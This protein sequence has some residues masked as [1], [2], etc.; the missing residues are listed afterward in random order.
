MFSLHWIFGYIVESVQCVDCNIIAVLF[1]VPQGC[2]LGLLQF[3]LYNASE[4]PAMA[5][6]H[7]T[8]ISL[9]PVISN[10]TYSTSAQGVVDATKRLCLPRRHHTRVCHCTSNLTLTSPSSSCLTFCLSSLNSDFLLSHLY[11]PDLYANLLKSFCIFGQVS[12]FALTAW[13][14]PC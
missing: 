2:I 14:Q 1:D 10:S 13:V 4:L 6:H 12:G 7:G 5:S 3:I 8:E 9:M 11:F